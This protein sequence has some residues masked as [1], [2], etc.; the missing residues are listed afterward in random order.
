MLKAL[1]ILSFTLI[2]V[3]VNKCILRALIENTKMEN[4]NRRLKDL[5]WTIGSCDS[6]SVSSHARENSKSI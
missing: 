5:T 2:F 1:E 4:S 6:S 3:T